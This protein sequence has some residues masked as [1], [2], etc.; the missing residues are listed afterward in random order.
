MQDHKGHGEQEYVGRRKAEVV[1]IE[2]QPLERAT[3]WDYCEGAD[4]P[5]RI[6]DALIGAKRRPWSNFGDV[7]VPVV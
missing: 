1:V 6:R 2:V 5:K 3:P 4:Q 7:W